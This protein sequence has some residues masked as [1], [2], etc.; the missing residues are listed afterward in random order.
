[1]T[2]MVI[3]R[4]V[5]KMTDRRNLRDKATSLDKQDNS[6]KKRRE[7]ERERKRIKRDGKV[8][9]VVVVAIKRT[10]PHRFTHSLLHSLA[11]TLTQSR[12]L[13]FLAGGPWSQ[14][15]RSGA[16]CQGAHR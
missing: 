2:K 5:I 14:W 3:I 11:P 1:M 9:V 13:I 15:S 10:H 8:I 16:S 4:I 12:R 7:R 6:T